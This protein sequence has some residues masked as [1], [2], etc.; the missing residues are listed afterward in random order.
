MALEGNSELRDGMMTTNEERQ[1][2]RAKNA[3]LPFLE[4]RLSVPKMYI[5][6]VWGGHKV[7][8]LAIDRDGVGDVHTVLLFA[9][10]YSP[11][12][13][14]NP[15]IVNRSIKDKIDQFAAISANYKYIA[16]VD[17]DPYLN[18]IPLDVADSL[19]EE[20]FSQDGIGRIGFITIKAQVDEE[21]KVNVEIKPERFRAKIAKIAD[22]YI[23]HHEA[24]WE[25]RA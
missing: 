5:D 22:D 1:L 6:A 17:H 25:I 9:R 16:V 18:R 13:E 2:G 23:Q 4:R 3:L 19:R 20:S 8:V 7:D 14:L 15:V 24:D 11:E 21:P 10:K 12:G